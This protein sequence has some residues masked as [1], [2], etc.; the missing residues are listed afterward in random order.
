MDWDMAQKVH[1]YMHDMA[2]VECDVVRWH[3]GLAGG[4]G[5]AVPGHDAVLTTP[6]ACLDFASGFHQVNAN[7]EILAVHPS[8]ISK[9]AARLEPEA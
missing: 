1:A 4:F 8:G 7:L 2:G 9:L 6:E 3:N 5:I